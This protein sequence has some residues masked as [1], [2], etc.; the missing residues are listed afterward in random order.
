M[1]DYDKQYQAMHPSQAQQFHAD[2]S[3]TP[4]N[5]KDYNPNQPRINDKCP[6]CGLRILFIG[7]GGWLTCS[8]LSCPEPVMSDAITAAVQQSNRELLERLK[9][10]T[11]TS[12]DEHVIRDAIDAEL[13]ALER[14]QA[15]EEPTDDL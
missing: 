8:N 6:A 3:Q 13:A 15:G 11:E 2:D 1:N 4:E 14:Q 5:R 12:R 7:A 9:A 10:V